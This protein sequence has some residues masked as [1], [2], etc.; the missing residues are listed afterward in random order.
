MSVARFVCRECE[1]LFPLSKAVFVPTSFDGAVT[2]VCEKCYRVRK[3]D[4]V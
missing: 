2:T 4:D 3:D 1:G